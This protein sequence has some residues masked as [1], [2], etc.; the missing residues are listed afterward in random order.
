MNSAAYQN[1]AT[2]LARFEAGDLDP[3]GFTHRE[4]VRMGFEL[5]RRAPFTEAADRFARALKR[6]AT[7]AGAPEKYH[8]TITVAFMALIAERVR[9]GEPGQ[10]FGAFAVANP[11]LFDRQVLTRWYDPA[12][13]ASPA[14]RRAFVLPSPTVRTG[15]IHRTPV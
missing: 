13:L 12:Q 7:A 2:D 1:S 10:D 11:D 15:P 6:M 3:A 5:A 8:E 4:H 14:A 9:E